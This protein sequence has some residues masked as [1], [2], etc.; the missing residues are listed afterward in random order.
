MTVLYQVLIGLLA[1]F[2]AYM[3]GLARRTSFRQ[4]TY[5]RARRFW[6]PFISGNLKIVSARFRDFNDWEA[7]GLVGVGGMQAAAELTAFLDDVG[8]RRLGASLEIVYHD[9][10]AGDLSGTSLVHRGSRR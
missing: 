2:I 6:R 7:S 9:R 4:L 5:W 1:T 10:I 3:A 8:Y